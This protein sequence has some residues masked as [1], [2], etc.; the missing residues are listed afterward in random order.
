MLFIFEKNRGI[1]GFEPNARGAGG[2][3]GE[4][5][6]V[7]EGSE[8]LIFRG[9][10]AFG[11]KI[12]PAAGWPRREGVRLS[13][14]FVVAVFHL[15]GRHR[16]AFTHVDFVDD[17]AVLIDNFVRTGLGTYVPAI[18][19]HVHTSVSTVCPAASE[20]C[21]SGGF[22]LKPSV[23][24]KGRQGNFLCTV[25]IERGRNWRNRTRNKRRKKE[26]RPRRHN[27]FPGEDKKFFRMSCARTER[28]V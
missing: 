24:C 15:R 27:F 5:R 12:P 13:F 14:G 22:C 11:Q 26:D 17:I 23:A 6:M 21:T 3:G 19:S 10:K 28:M 18:Q 9:E 8:V 7:S 20:L 16:F 2:E 4:G 25:K 1:G